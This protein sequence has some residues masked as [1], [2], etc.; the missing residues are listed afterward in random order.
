MSSVVPPEDREA[1]MRQLALFSVCSFGIGPRKCLSFDLHSNWFALK[2]L[3]TYESYSQVLGAA[4]TLI[5]V[6][7]F[8]GLIVVDKYN[9]AGLISK[10]LIS[11]YSLAKLWLIT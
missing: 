11:Q 8:N 3:F 7:L 6:S 5:N 10:R 4:M 9:V 2:T 1:R